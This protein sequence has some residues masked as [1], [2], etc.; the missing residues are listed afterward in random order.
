MKESVGEVAIAGP[1]PQIR[2]LFEITGLTQVFRIYDDAAAALKE[3]R[4]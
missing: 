1:K 3:A 4:G 2:R